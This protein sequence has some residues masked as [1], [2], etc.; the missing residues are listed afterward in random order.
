MK[1]NSP[2]KGMLNG[3]GPNMAWAM[4]VLLFAGLLYLFWYNSLD[5]TKNFTEFMDRV[6][7]DKVKAVIIND[8]HVSVELKDKTRFETTI[9]PSETV[10]KSLRD[11][12]VEMNVY[13]QERQSWF[14]SLILSLLPL[15]L[16]FRD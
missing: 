5:Q 3:R 8:Q 10:W 6:E 16:I 13:P 7:S 9:I 15:L 1:K 14:F 12:K 11:H 4:L 2:N